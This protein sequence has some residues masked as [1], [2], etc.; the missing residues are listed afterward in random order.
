ML[1]L[2]R[3]LP[4]DLIFYIQGIIRKDYRKKYYKICK[5]RIAIKFS[6]RQRLTFRT[7]YNRTLISFTIY[8]LYS[9]KGRF[10]YRWFFYQGRES[11]VFMD[12]GLVSKFV[13]V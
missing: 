5:N 12:Q 11:F 9:D 7:Y 8:P 3:F 2:Q 4:S 10:K 1:F 6:K 13:Y